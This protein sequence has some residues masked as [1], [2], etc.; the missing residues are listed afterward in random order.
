MPEQTN[1]AHPRSRGD[2]SGLNGRPVLGLGSSPLARGPPPVS[3]FVTLTS[4]LIPARAGTTF[5]CTVHHRADGAHPRSRGDHR[6]YSA[7]KRR[8]RGSSPLARGP[9]EGWT[10][11]QRCDGLI[12][13]RAG[14]TLGGS[15]R[16]GST[17]AHPRS[18]GD[19][20]SPIRMTGNP[21]GSSPL[22]RG[23]RSHR[24]KNF[25]M[26]GLIPARAGTTQ[27]PRSKCS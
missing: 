21:M 3:T 23:P 26:T 22:A 10:P 4:G 14:T 13:A 1:W 18:R 6:L 16:R 11:I 9:H 27:L 25:R 15:A 12:P 8:A 7:G 24:S 20:A 19:H 5:A 17:R 2:H